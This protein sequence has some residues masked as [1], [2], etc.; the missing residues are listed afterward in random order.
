MLDYH[1]LKPEDCYL[2]KG[3]EIHVSYKRESEEEVS[4]ECLDF[5]WIRIPPPSSAFEILTLPP[6]PSFSLA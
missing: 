6:H 4:G 1:H 5:V 2:M 3:D